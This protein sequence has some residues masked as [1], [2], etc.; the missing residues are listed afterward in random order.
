MDDNYYSNELMHWGIKGQKWGV[1]RFQ[2]EDGTL[3]EEGRKRYMTNGSGLQKRSSI[4]PKERQ[5]IRD[6]VYYTKEKDA[7][8][9][10]NNIYKNKNK[11]EQSADLELLSVYVKNNPRLWSDKSEQASMVGIIDRDFDGR[12]LMES[13]SEGQTDTNY[14]KSSSN[15]WSKL[16][17]AWRKS[18]DMRHKI[19]AGEETI[20]NYVDAIVEQVNAQNTF[21][22]S[23]MGDL[24]IEKTSTNLDSIRW[25]I[26]ANKN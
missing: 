7:Q 11:E 21:I 13:I 15:A 16:N 25:I 5:R 2:N 3:T 8:E 19:W 23:R 12:Y 17:K 9:K 10:V 14:S 4:L 24:G 18:E 22:Y 6:A 1:R 26:G 20:E